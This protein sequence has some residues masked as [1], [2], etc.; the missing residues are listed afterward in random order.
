[1]NEKKDTGAPPERDLEM[2]E[3]LITQ[4]SVEA[5]VVK[6]FLESNGIPVVLK[7]LVV[8]SVH[9]FTAD[10]LGQI[11]IMVPSK[12][13]EIAKMLLEKQGIM[14]TNKKRIRKKIQLPHKDDM[15]A[16]QYPVFSLAG[17]G[18]KIALDI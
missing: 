16:M 7:G 15:S 4:G 10:G 2:K 18:I 3:V 12:V 13:F 9:A 8:Q 5:E 11:R 17:V 6:S 14:P 1:M